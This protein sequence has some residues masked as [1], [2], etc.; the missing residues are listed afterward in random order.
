MTNEKFLTSDHDLLIRL[1]TKLDIIDK[2]LDSHIQEHVTI[3]SNITKAFI[4]SIFSLVC[5]IFLYVFK[6]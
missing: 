4:T 3:R 6:K 5:S 1:D 2:K